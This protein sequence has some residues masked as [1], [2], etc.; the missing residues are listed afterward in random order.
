MHTVQNERSS[1]NGEHLKYQHMARRRSVSVP[2]CT[3]VGMCSNMA[4]KHTGETTGTH[5]HT[6]TGEWDR[7]RAR[8]GEMATNI[9][10]RKI[11]N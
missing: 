7:W 11:A 2:V 3:W 1:E 4:I 9:W 10:E 5:T 6:H 8:G